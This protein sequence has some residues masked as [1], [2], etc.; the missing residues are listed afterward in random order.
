MSRARSRSATFCLRAAS[1]RPWVPASRRESASRP[2]PRRSHRAKLARL[3][4]SWTTDEARNTRRSPLTDLLPQRAD[5]CSRT[6][7]GTRNGLRRM[8]NTGR[9]YRAARRRYRETHK[10]EM[11]ERR[12]LRLQ[13]D[14]RFSRTRARP[15]PRMAAQEALRQ[16]LPALAGRLRRHA[17]AAEWRLRHLQAIRPGA[18]CRSLPRVRQG[19]RAPLRQMQQR[20]RVLRR[21]PRASA[22]G[23]RVPAGVVRPG[24]GK[25]H[26]LGRSS[27]NRAVA[28]ERGWASLSLRRQSPMSPS[29]ADLTF[30]SALPRVIS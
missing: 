3:R 15:R 19:A 20:A 9:R 8:P 21:Q 23:R 4:N 6:A 2:S 11:R 28:R 13:N 22:D 26:D 1:C 29:V 27:R 17:Q 5:Q 18:V 12:R 14:P 7:R 25:F 10:Q 30:L 16:G 24:A